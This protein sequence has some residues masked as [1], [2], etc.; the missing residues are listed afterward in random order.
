MTSRR[1]EE[2]NRKHK[3]DKLG[4]REGVKKSMVTA[5]ISTGESGNLN[6]NDIARGAKIDTRDKKAMDHIYS[7]LRRRDARK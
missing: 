4:G 1:D 3:F 5:F 2:R 7:Q 6:A